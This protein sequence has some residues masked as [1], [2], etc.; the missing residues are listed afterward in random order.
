MKYF[1]Q[2]ELMKICREIFETAGASPESAE[3]V[4]KSFV[5]ANLMGFDS[6]GIAMLYRYLE[7]IDF[8]W[9]D[10]KAEPEMEKETESTALIDGHW[11]FGQ[12]ACHY[13]MRVAQEKARK[14]GIASVSVHNASHCGRLGQ[15][16]EAVSQK[17]FIGIAMVNNHGAGN[18]VAPFGG[19]ERKLS[20]NPFSV[21]I[22]YKEGQPILLDMT[23]SVVAERKIKLKYYNKEQ[24]PA[25]WFI[26]SDG[27]TPTDPAEFYGDPKGALLPF[28][29][30]VG[31]KGF[32]LSLMVDILAGALSGA[33]CSNPDQ[34]QVGN[35]FFG[36]VIDPAV[37]SAHFSGMVE[38]LIDHVKSCKTQEGVARIYYPGEP[39]QQIYKQRKA[40]GIPVSEDTWEL[41]EKALNKLN[42][43]YSHSL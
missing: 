30:D 12:V 13:A 2:D 1:S 14:T 32:G 40:E 29:G 9:L 10:P 42:L 7:F 3:L 11:A 25:G 23:T 8:G 17:G 4:A 27:R 5:D 21:A 18:M 35:A 28:G 24:V 6:H 20:T 38:G 41:V 39:E 34:K 37:Q 33:G 26:T 16:P 15:Y 31:Y 19:T 22:P 36:I 43:S